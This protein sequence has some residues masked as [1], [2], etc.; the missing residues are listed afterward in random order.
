LPEWIDLKDIGEI[1]FYN[2][3]DSEEIIKK[4]LQVIKMNAIK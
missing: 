4:A 2:S 1:K 3:I